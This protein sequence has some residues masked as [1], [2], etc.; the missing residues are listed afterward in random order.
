MEDN[1]WGDD[2]TVES[3]PDEPT[4]VPGDGEKLVLKAN[5]NA[6]GLIPIVLISFF[7]GGLIMDPISRADFFPEP[8]VF[9]GVSFLATTL[10]FMV[11]LSFIWTIFDKHWWTIIIDGDNVVLKRYLPLKINSFSYKQ[12][13]STDIEMVVME[14]V[15]VEHND[16]DD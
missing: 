4:A 12:L 5:R 14:R 1:W 9:Y 6:A 13:K 11:G 15:W 10:L 7:F 8:Y 3:S 2:K 16:S